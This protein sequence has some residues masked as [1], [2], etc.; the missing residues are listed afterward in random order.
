[1]RG[2]QQ[3]ERPSESGPG[4][5]G[6]R[7]P[8]AVGS[9]S[10][11]VLEN[12]LSPFGF[13]MLVKARACVACHGSLVN[14]CL[15]ATSCMSPTTLRP[16]LGTMQSAWAGVAMHARVRPMLCS[17][18]FSPSPFA[19]PLLLKG[20][21]RHLLIPAA[22]HQSSRRARASEPYANADDECPILA[23]QG[24]KNNLN[25][26]KNEKKSSRIRIRAPFF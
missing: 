19:L 21:T 6:P 22:S 20:K 2:V 26:E 3:L 12:G 9:V 5:T 16:L 14:V 24:K 7:C 25:F 17:S 4:A 8:C 1:M 18:S 13:N 15:S 23:R 11:T 10:L